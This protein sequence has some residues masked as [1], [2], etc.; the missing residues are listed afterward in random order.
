MKLLIIILIPICLFYQQKCCHA[1]TVEASSGISKNRMQFEL[2][3]VYLIE[4]N[5]DEKV[6][7]WSIPSALTRFGLSDQIEVLL[8][9]PFVKQEAY[10]FDQLQESSLLLENVQLGASI[11]LWKQD[12]IIPEASVMYRML[13]PVHE[14]TPGT[15]SHLLGLN[16]SNQLND[17]TLLTYN[18][19]Y[20]SDGTESSLYYILNL[21]YDLGRTM[22]CFTELIGNRFDHGELK[23]M[24]NTGFGF[25]LARDLILDLSVA[26]GL[27]HQMIFSGGKL[28][29]SLGI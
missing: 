10:V 5:G 24:F 3:S 7:S 27:D 4:Q 28:S 15:M 19:G 2:E 20:L 16:F 8:L 26:A 11:N 12:G 29:Y 14:L 13:L 6:R 18:L 1:Q 21:A 17:R 23:N 22:H 9:V 25:N